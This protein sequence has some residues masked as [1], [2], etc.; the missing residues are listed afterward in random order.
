MNERVI[1]KDLPCSQ[2]DHVGFEGYAVYKCS[3]DK[4][5]GDDGKHHLVSNENDLWNFSIPCK[6]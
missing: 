2:E 3:R 4:G 1:N 5:R 6:H